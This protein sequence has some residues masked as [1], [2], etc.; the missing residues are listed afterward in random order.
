MLLPRRMHRSSRR[1]TLVL[2]AGLLQ[3]CTSGDAD[4]PGAAP[5]ADD[6]SEATDQPG[7]ASSELRVDLAPRQAAYAA[8][9]PVLV[10]VTISNV[11]AR[12][13]R[14]L[15]WMLPAAD[16]EES[17]FVV[18][19][20]RQRAAFLGAHY[21]RPGAEPGDFVHLAA[22]ASI[23]RQVD[24]A[25]FYDL[26]RTGDHE[27]QLVV[28]E[29]ELRPED[30]AT[31]A[32]VRSNVARI[33]IEGRA[34]PAAEPVVADAFAGSLG[35]SRCTTTQQ[36]TVTQAAAV[37]NAMSDNAR[38]YLAGSPSATPRYTTWFGAFSSA[39]WSTAATHF[40]AIADAFDN[41][42]ITVD[43]GCKKK[44]YAYVYP[45]QPY[46]IY[47]CSV[48]WSAPL[49]GTDSKGGTLVHEMSHF[50]VVAATDDWAYGQS[51]CKSLA[52]SDP[53]RALNNADSHEYFAEN[54]PALP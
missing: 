26:T 41:K 44:Y 46:K 13:A 49:E 39:G 21:K 47:V 33:W 12:E 54:T 38:S 43:C 1:I 51:A 28:D 35:F 37:A 6:S 15:A 17:L 24:L 34:A 53:Q 32:V 29:H 23:T 3:A 22:G 40:A 45:T 9:E 42:A 16:L 50:N 25:R 30:G 4:D 10:D 8:D 5:P 27:V 20:R 48:F 7:A 52:L 2:L 18:G 11:G 14:L 19:H 36:A 31:A